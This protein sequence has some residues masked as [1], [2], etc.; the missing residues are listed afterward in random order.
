MHRNG[1]D[2]SRIFASIVDELPWQKLHS[3]TRR[4]FLPA[5]WT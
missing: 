4:N 1:E 5:K 3:T 2:E